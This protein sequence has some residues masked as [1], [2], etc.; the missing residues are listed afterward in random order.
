MKRNKIILAVL[1]LS[2]IA[3][4]FTGCGGVE[5]LVV[6]PI[7]NGD[8]DNGDGD[9]E[10]L[11]FWNGWFDGEEWT[12]T[13][14]YNGPQADSKKVYCSDSLDNVWVDD[15][16]PRRLHLKIT[17]DN[18]NV[19]W[20][21]AQIV[22]EKTFGGYG[23]YTFYIDNVIMEMEDGRKYNATKLDKNV[24]IGL[25]TYDNSCSHPS[26]NEIDLE[27]SQ[28]GT[29]YFKEGWFIVWKDGIQTLRDRR[30]FSIQLVGKSSIHSFD[31]TEDGINF[32]SIC[33][34]NEELAH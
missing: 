19:R 3:L 23:K 25:Y 7:D 17:Y 11:K 13:T 8:G 31:W 1:I 34:S 9:E 12:I 18:A 20:N 22:S 28:W 14:G 4:V 26:K 32:E 30:N 24:V 2:V 6:P 21:C 33:G 5:S 10:E 16:N 27:F 29:S 15:Q